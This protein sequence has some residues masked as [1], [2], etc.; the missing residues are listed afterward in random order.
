MGK[1]AA[2]KSSPPSPQSPEEEELV[3]SGLEFLEV[4][5]F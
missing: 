1:P 3:E 5:I 2:G 4:G